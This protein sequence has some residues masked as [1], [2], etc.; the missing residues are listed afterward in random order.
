MIVDLADTP[1]RVACD[2]TVFGTPH[3]VAGFDD[4][5]LSNIPIESITQFVVRIH[6]ATKQHEKTDH[7]TPTTQNKRRPFW[8]ERRATGVTI[9]GH[10][11]TTYSSRIGMTTAKK[12]GSAGVLRTQGESESENSRTIS[13]L[14]V[15]LSTSRT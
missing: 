10:L 2:V 11:P 4:A 9:Y 6:A 8:K 15:T 1:S 3:V 14:L 5:I 13:S 7:Q 12:P